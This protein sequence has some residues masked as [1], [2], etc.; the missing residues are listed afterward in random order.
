[1]TP[2]CHKRGWICKIALKNKHIWNSALASI[3]YH[4]SWY[5]FCTKFKREN[6][7]HYIVSKYLV[8]PSKNR[9]P[10]FLKTLA[11]P[12]GLELDAIEV[13]EQHEKHIAGEIP[14]ILLNNKPGIG[15]RKNC[16]KKIVSF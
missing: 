7:C 4:G 14:I 2:V 10:D 3:K 5:P 6:L 11:Y 15:S 12:N 8:P 9:R 13:Q 1:M 16:A